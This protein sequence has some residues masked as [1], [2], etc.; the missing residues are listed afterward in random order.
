[1]A[2]R[3]VDPAE[4]P[5]TFVQLLPE[6]VDY[7]H[8]IASNP[9]REDECAFDDTGGEPARAQRSTHSAHV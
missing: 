4:D 7:T 1:V 5:T 8:M 6:R 9:H 2:D 3:G